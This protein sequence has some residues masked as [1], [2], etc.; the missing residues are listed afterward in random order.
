ELL[1]AAAQS[2][3]AGDPWSGLVHFDVVEQQKARA[4]LRGVER[5]VQRRP[6]QAQGIVV[7]QQVLDSACVR[8][9]S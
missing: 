9:W 3:D 8:E 1:V 4:P 6:G 2:D 7:G 5:G